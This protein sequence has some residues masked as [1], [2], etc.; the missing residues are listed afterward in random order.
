MLNPLHISGV[1][2]RKDDSG[3]STNSHKKN[4]GD[5]VSSPALS[6]VVCPVIICSNKRL[7]NTLLLDFIHRLMSKKKGLGTSTKSSI[8][9]PK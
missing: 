8:K 6:T 9:S 5:A 4:V 7:R 3:G 2:K 1:R